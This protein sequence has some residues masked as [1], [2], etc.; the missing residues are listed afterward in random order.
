MAPTPDYYVV[1]LLRFNPAK[2]KWGKILRAK[3]PDGASSFAPKKILPKGTYRWRLGFK[4]TGGTILDPE[5]GVLAKVKPR[6]LFEDSCT[7]FERLEVQPGTS[8]LAS[9]FRYFTA[10][11]SSVTYTFN[12]AL[13]ATSYAVFISREGSLWKKLTVKPSA[14]NPGAGTLS[15]TVKGH[16]VGDQY[17]WFVVPLNYDHPKPF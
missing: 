9:P 4:Q 1:E 6:L 5:G 15:V 12:A 11:E 13:N 8:T 14:D 7:E 17:D 16:V 10:G 2:N 3:L